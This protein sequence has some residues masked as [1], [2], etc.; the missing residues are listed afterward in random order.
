MK[1]LETQFNLYKDSYKTLSSYVCFVKAVKKVLPADRYI[2]SGFN[3][4]VD[5]E[6]YSKSIKANLIGS[7]KT[8]ARL[9]RG[10]KNMA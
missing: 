10:T 9:K 7:I 5:K 1:E 4:L 6:D 3:K 2:V 8:I